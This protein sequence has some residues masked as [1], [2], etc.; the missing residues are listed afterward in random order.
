VPFCQPF[1]H[2]S[3]GGG[4][5]R[6]VWNDCG[7]P[8][9]QVIIIAIQAAALVGVWAAALIITA[10]WAGARWGERAGLQR[11]NIVLDEGKIFIHP[12]YG[13]LH[14][15]NGSLECGP[16]KT[17]ESARWITLPTFLVEL[18]RN[19]LATHDHPHAFVTAEGKLFRRPN[20]SDVPC[21]RR[22]TAT[23]P[24]YGPRSGSTPS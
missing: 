7:P 10:A 6:Y 24:A 17:A 4:A 9:E 3:A 11:S 1:G 8:P 15:V 21:T 22:P 16:P 18:L 13:A 2:A 12:D 14:E 20:F 23:S 19:H 5:A